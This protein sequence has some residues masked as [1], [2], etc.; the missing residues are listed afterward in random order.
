M[1]DPRIELVFWW[2]RCDLEELIVANRLQISMKKILTRARLSVI[3]L[4][5]WR[6]YGRKARDRYIQRKLAILT[7][8]A[9]GAREA[10]AGWRESQCCEYLHG[11][12][13]H[14]WVLNLPSKSC[15]GQEVASRIADP[16]KTEW[17]WRERHCN[18]SSLLLPT[19]LL[20]A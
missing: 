12:R 17:T 4:W 2:P 14:R 6:N 20:L 10:P 11:R 16:R 18:W 3:S 7:S 1:A 15:V 5:N 8:R 19:P 9:G 13:C